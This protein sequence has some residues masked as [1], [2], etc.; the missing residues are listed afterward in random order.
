MKT[1]TVKTVSAPRYTTTAPL[2]LIVDVK[3]TVDGSDVD[4]KGIPANTSIANFGA[5]GVIVSESKEA[6][7]T[8]VDNMLQSSK[9]ILDSIDY[10]KQV[11]AS[12]SDIMKQLNPAV[13]KE[14][15]RD[16]AITNLSKRVDDMQNGLDKII[17]ILTASNK[18]QGYGNTDGTE[19]QW[20]PEPEDGGSDERD[21]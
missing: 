2:S 7:I 8:E 9:Q 20:R 6:M 11:V 16:E 18:I 10:H 1:G 13:A 3:V 4:F 5:S 15:Q 21:D 17:N 12:Y 14:Q 19:A